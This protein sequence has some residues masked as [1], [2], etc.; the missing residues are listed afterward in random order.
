MKKIGFI[1]LV[2]CFLMV[3]SVSAISIDS[4]D[5]FGIVDGVPETHDDEVVLV[6]WSESDVTGVP[7]YRIFYVP[8]GE[9]ASNPML[10]NGYASRSNFQTLGSDK[11][12]VD[13]AF[14]NGSYHLF[15]T[16]TGFGIMSYLLNS[17]DGSY[18]SLS[19]YG[20]QTTRGNYHTSLSVVDD[21]LGDGE[22]VIINSRSGHTS[23]CSPF[24]FKYNSSSDTMEWRQDLAEGLSNFSLVGGCKI[25][26]TYNM[27]GFNETDVIISH[28]NGASWTGRYYNQSANLWVDAPELVVGLPDIQ[29]GHES[30]SSM[31]IEELG[32]IRHE[33]ILSYVGN[34]N[35]GAY[36]W[37]ND[38]WAESYAGSDGIYGDFAY[39]DFLNSSY[40]RIWYSPQGWGSIYG[41]DVSYESHAYFDLTG[42][43]SNPF[44][45]FSVTG[46]DDG[47]EGN[48]L[49]SDSFVA[50]MY[51]GFACQDI[52]DGSVWNMTTDVNC[53]VEGVDGR[54][55]YG[56]SSGLFYANGDNILFDGQGHTLIGSMRS[57]T[58]WNN[59]T[60]MNV[61]VVHD[62][63]DVSQ[64]FFNRLGGSNIVFQNFNLSVERENY[65]G[66][67][68]D[69]QYGYNLYGLTL[70]NVH[71]K[72]NNPSSHVVL[73]LGGSVGTETHNVVLQDVILENTFSAG[74]W[75]TPAFYNINGGIFGLELNNVD[76]I[77]LNG[78]NLNN[79]Y[80][81]L[82]DGGTWDGGMVADNVHDVLV[83][84][85][86]MTALWNP[87]DECDVVCEQQ[88]F[89]M[90]TSDSSNITLLDNDFTSYV[91]VGVPVTIIGGSYAQIGLSGGDSIVSDVTFKDTPYINLWLGNEENPSSNYDFYNLQM[92]DE[93]IFIETPSMI[94]VNVADVDFFNLTMSNTSNFEVLQDGSDVDF[95]NSK[96]E[97]LVGGLS[98]PIET[99]IYN[100]VFSSVERQNI[101]L[102]GDDHVIEGNNFTNIFSSIIGVDGD[103]A[104]NIL[105][106]DNYWYGLEG[107]D[108]QVVHF[109][110][111]SGWDSGWS[112][113]HFVGNTFDYS[114]LPYGNWVQMITIDGGE[115]IGFSDFLMENNTFIGYSYE[116]EVFVVDTFGLHGAGEDW[117]EI[118]AWDYESKELLIPFWTGNYDVLFLEST[119]AGESNASD[120]LI[121]GE[122]ECIQVADSSTDCSS[123]TNYTDF[124]EVLFMPEDAGSKW[125]CALDNS[126]NAYLNEVTDWVNDTSIQ[127]EYTALAGRNNNIDPII[128]FSQI[129][130]GMIIRGNDYFGVGG[131][132]YSSG[133]AGETAT[134]WLVEDNKM[135]NSSYGLTL[136]GVWDVEVRG[137]EYYDQTEY[138]I[139]CVGLGGVHAQGWN[140]HDNLLNGVDGESAS[141]NINRCSGVVED[142]LLNHAGFVV[143]YLDDL[144]VRNNQVVDYNVRDGG[145]YGGFGLRDCSNSLIENNSVEA[146]MQVGNGNYYLDDSVAVFYGSN[147]A[148]TCILRDNVFKGLDSDATIYYGFKRVSDN[149]TILAPDNIRFEDNDIDSK[150]VISD[151]ESTDLFFDGNTFR[152]NI[153]DLGLGTDFCDYS[154]LSENYFIGGVYSGRNVDNCAE[155]SEFSGASTT[156]FSQVQD[157]TNVPLRL[158]N[159]NGDIDWL[160]NV[161][162]SETDVNFDDWVEIEQDRISVNSDQIS[163]LNTSATLTFENVHALNSQVIKV[164][165][166]PFLNFLCQIGII[167]LNNDYNKITGEYVMDV[168]HFSTYELDYVPVLEEED[169]MAVL[170]D[171]VLKILAGFG[172][173]AGVVGLYFG[174]RILWNLINGHKWNYNMKVKMGG[175]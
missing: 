115:S 149:V 171:V 52:I 100:S 26:A 12:D 152:K 79:V 37:F 61:D 93:E 6:N 45:R 29:S 143:S 104:D 116:A 155:A 120:V 97:N 4:I 105:W 80:G 112:N 169:S 18:L 31:H 125:F 27:L 134:G 55:V 65:D 129:V 136:R 140:V 8:D 158:S 44:A 28:T 135:Y 62:S 101:N 83:K 131:M 72:V 142:N 162:L 90:R 117:N 113:L 70:E 98:L 1:L 39:L 10:T 128:F 161:D 157:W 36:R 68:L 102:N 13:V 88:G 132:V 106:K 119:V 153:L 84:D 43:P 141:I 108:A 47:G 75:G 124:I 54:S 42:Q 9:T 66:L 51:G 81:F 170:W 46:Y 163:V 21:L 73:K 160:V 23:Y 99:D 123:L 138:A 49:P 175:R 165:S 114:I 126:G 145:L 24:V 91:A 56:G 133:I 89:A 2:L 20:N 77:N 50:N 166:N 76:I 111:D 154:D 35:G 85:L 118:P 172:I 22:A 41:Q 17:S 121:C 87:N 156:D 167:C 137:N 33:Y 40:N 58:G 14:I 164:Y 11:E 144:S 127:F 122:P 53:F 16:N 147:N 94:I 19:D 5:T 48:T 86:I 96:F 151:S 150:I 69:L 30:D 146:Q 148:D 15:V 168:T 139:G 78:G 25:L 32:F 34:G 107:G 74:S 59:A 60:W 3:S 63:D 82:V 95:F 159:T 67:T 174:L 38:A 173:L 57:Q 110:S 71:I 7:N 109:V 103:G 92:V 64:P 130:D